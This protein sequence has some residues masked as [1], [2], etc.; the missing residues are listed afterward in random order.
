MENGSPDK[1][2]NREC[3]ICSG[4]NDR[5]TAYQKY[6]WEENDT[7]LPA[8]VSNLMLVRDLRPDSN[9]KQQILQCPGCGQYYLYESDYEYLVNGSEDE[10]TLTRLSDEQASGY[11]NS[12]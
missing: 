2:K 8:A 5:E 6:G 4:L 3:P 9:R 7:Q 11:L 1:R 10:Q 12:P